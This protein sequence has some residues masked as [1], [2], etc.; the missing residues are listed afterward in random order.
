MVSV[1]TP[2]RE[3]DMKEMTAL[4]NAFRLNVLRRQTS[5]EIAEWCDLMFSYNTSIV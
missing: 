2:L 4:V 5:E 3:S 1:I